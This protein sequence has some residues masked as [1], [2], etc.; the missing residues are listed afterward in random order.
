MNATY[1]IGSDSYG[2]KIE[3]SKSGKR[4]TFKRGFGE[5]MR[6]WLDPQGR[7]RVF[8]SIG[9]VVVG[10]AVTSLDPHF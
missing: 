9:H 7:W 1:F 4:A 2:G 8:K 3:I 10:E 6:L 5:P